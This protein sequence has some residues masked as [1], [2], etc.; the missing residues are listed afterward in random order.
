MVFS[1]RLNLF[2]GR[3][4]PPGKPEP[5]N[6]G[7]KALTFFW[8]N[9]GI[10]QFESKKSYCLVVSKIIHIHLDIYQKTAYLVVYIYY[11]VVKREYKN[12]RWWFQPIWKILVKIDHFPK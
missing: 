4:G 8:K 2:N 5:S 11:L 6:V 1:K 3:L 12:T 10:S 9:F 7:V